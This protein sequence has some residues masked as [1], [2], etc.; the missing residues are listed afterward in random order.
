MLH[1]VLAAANL[2]PVSTAYN[3]DDANIYALIKEPAIPKLPALTGPVTTLALPHCGGLPSDLTSDERKALRLAIIQ[4]VVRR[5]IVWE[6]PIMVGTA[7]NFSVVNVHEPGHSDIKIVPIVLRAKRIF[8]GRPAWDNVKLL[9][10]EEGGA[11]LYFGRCMAF[12]RDKN[13]S[14]FVG[15]RWYQSVTAN[16]QALDETAMLPRLKLTKINVTIRDVL[17]SVSIVPAA[18][19]INGAL[20]IPFNDEYWAMQSSMEQGQYISNHQ[21]LHFP[22]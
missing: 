15:I 10:D 9:V 19:I 18:S 16:G 3:V 6:E 20:L 22:L 2:P 4:A 14:V 17:E 1:N 5:L 13:G 11:R 8:R 12:F 7:M 21:S